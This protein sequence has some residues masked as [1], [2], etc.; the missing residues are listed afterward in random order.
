MFDSLLIANR[1]EIARRIIRTARRMGLRTIAVHSEADAG[2]PHVREADEALCIGP[3]P[4]RDS[5]LD[6]EAILRAARASGA[7]ALHPGYGF[8]SENPRL[9]AACAAA[10]IVF[11]GPPAE[12]IATMGSKIEAKRLAAAAGVP[13]IPGFADDTG[14]D[15]A[16]LRA[17]G[18]VGL[19]VMI[20]ASAGGGGKGMRVVT[21]MDD[22]AAAV[23]TARREA[24]AAFGDDRLLME[25]LV[26]EARHVEVQIAADDHGRV[27]HLFERDCSV[28]R[29]N[30]KVLEEAPAPNLP[31]PVRQR[32]LGDAVRLASTIGYR[33]LGTMEFL[34]DATS[35]EH[36]FLEMNTRLQVEHP[37]T[38][39]VTG[40]DLVEWQLRI[41]AGE[42]LPL[43]QDEIRLTGHAIEARLAAER[44][45]EGYAP[46]SGTIA[47]WREPRGAGGRVDAG[48]ETGSRVG[49]FYDSMIAKVIAHGATREE[50]VKKLARALDETA[51]LGLS[52]NRAFL[53]DIVATPAFAEG[54]ATTSLLP[55]TW[56]EGWR[57]ADERPDDHGPLV[58]GCRVSVHDET[59]ST[60]WHRLRGFRVM[61]ASGRDC[62]QPVSVTVDGER[63]E[64]LVRID[65]NRTAVQLGDAWC[66]IDLARRGDHHVVTLAGRPE[67][68]IAVVDGASV[69]LRFGGDEIS[70]EV[71]HVGDFDVHRRS[72]D[73]DDGRL[74]AAMPGLVAEIAVMVGDVVAEGQPVVTLESMKLFHTLTAPRT[75]RIAAI[76]VGAGQAIEKGRVLVVFADADPE[77]GAPAT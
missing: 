6:I 13:T 29:S 40:L 76:E 23:A 77:A 41:A 33:N 21:R 18:E 16:F 71:H 74:V 46:A 72:S 59:G 65:G 57:P 35:G 26:G 20:K 55:R 4:A 66:E 3:A 36:F 7:Q 50:A 56:P 5:Y 62:T 68:G 15:A 39:M 45:Q 11:V 30:Q 49:V 51:V 70:A 58:A 12:V 69:A 38:E 54:A 9:A 2:A 19:P 32:L 34:V 24:M 37:V 22:L 17:A 25:R 31:D 52:T 42:P 48:V 53:A 67:R 60:P 44:P 14:D 61:A 43:A 63:H 73:R 47:L 64:H 75:A 10:G 27:V 1:G 28:Q 8:L